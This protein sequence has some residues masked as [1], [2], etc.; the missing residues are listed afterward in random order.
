MLAGLCL[1]RGKRP[2]NAQWSRYRAQYVPFVTSNSRARL[3]ACAGGVVRLCCTSVL[4][5][6]GSMI[7]E[8]Q[9]AKIAVKMLRH[10][11]W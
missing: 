3:T 7:A 2:G 9:G 8:I 5:R 1:S 6:P 10:P 11:S 4:Q